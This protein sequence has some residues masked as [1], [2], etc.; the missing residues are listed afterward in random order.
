MGLP[1]AP[2]RQSCTSLHPPSRVPTDSL[3]FTKSSQH[4]HP[5]QHKATYARGKA[6]PREGS[7]CLWAPGH[8]AAPE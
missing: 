3:A 7:F 8:R 2:Q 1:T 6:L 4:R 5:G